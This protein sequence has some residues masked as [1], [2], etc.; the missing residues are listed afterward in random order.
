M[1][2]K[3]FA[4]NPF[5]DKLLQWIG[6]A[7]YHFDDNTQTSVKVKVLWELSDLDLRQ[8]VWLFDRICPRWTIWHNHVCFLEISSPSIAMA[9]LLA[10]N[11]IVWQI[12]V[13]MQH[14]TLSHNVVVELLCFVLFVLNKNSD[15]S[16]TRL[17][18]CSL[19]RPDA[20]ICRG[21]GLWRQRGSI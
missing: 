19:G 5:L 7:K 11:K 15:H 12:K 13:L 9:I 16:S 3:M 21:S 17:E 20:G 18:S 6:T 14:W 4:R 2:L 1:T 10:I 8:D